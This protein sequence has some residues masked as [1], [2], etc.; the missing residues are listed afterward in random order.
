MLPILQVGPLAIQFPGLIL[1]AGVWLG[2][3]LAEAHAAR[4]G[5]A[6]NHLYNLVFILLIAGLI[7]ARLVYA[8]RYPQIFAASP[9]SLLSLN[10]GLLDTWGGLATGALAAAVYGQRK[11][12]ALWPTLDALTPFLAVIA[13]AVAL[14][15][16]AAG[17][18]FGA[19]TNL[20]WGIELWGTRRH[21][22]QVYEALAAGLILVVLWPGRKSFDTWPG[23]AYFLAFVAASSLSR[24]L[25]ES[26]R[27]DSLLLPGGLRTA[28]AAAWVIL[29]A[30]LWGLRQ[31]MAEEG[32]L[33][34]TE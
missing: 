32:T 25:L 4:R 6:P 5:V 28:Q 3:L 19:P 12:L 8:L 18:A 31:R 10:P 7:G 27:G 13:V 16:L 21:P 34:K 20:P 30:S 14:S 11:G 9:L 22:S 1:L 26:L 24:L 29:I 33:R 2:L 23:G 17:T 15:H